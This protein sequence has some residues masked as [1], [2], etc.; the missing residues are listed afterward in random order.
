V[1]DFV[2]VG[3]IIAAVLTADD[4]EARRGEFA[5][6]VEAVAERYPLYAQLGAAAAA[7]AV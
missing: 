6:R 2:E 5:E 7:A 4:F 3:K 1:E